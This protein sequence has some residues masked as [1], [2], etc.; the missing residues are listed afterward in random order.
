MVDVTGLADAHGVDRDKLRAVL[1]AA[2]FASALYR[3]QLATAYASMDVFFHPGEH[4]TFCQTVQ[5]ALASGVPVIAPD[6]AAEQRYQ[7]VLAIISDGLSI[8]QVAQRSWCRARRC[9]RGWPATRPK[10]S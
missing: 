8:S 6:A 1:P 3:H 2:V 10:A 7:A 4:E 9:M 5:E